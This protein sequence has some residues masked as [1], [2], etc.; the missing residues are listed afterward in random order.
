MK[1]VKNIAHIALV[2]SYVQLASLHFYAWLVG[3]ISGG[4]FVCDYFNEV[5]ITTPRFVPFYSFNP[6]FSAIFIIF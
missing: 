4:G 5:H 2:N 1:S 3:V 6:T